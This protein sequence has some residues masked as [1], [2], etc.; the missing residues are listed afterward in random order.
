VHDD[1]AAWFTV[2]LRDLGDEVPAWRGLLAPM[3]SP[4]TASAGVT[5]QFLDHAADYHDRYANVAYFRMVL[6]GAFARLERPPAPRA[7]LDIGSGSGNS[8][9]PLLDRFPDAFVVATD[10]SAPLL[11]ILR[12]H[13]A[14]E[15]RYRGRYALVAVDAVGAP[16][17]R[18]S[19]DLVVGAAILHHVLEPD[20]VIDECR[21][22]L[23]PGGLAV[24]LEP[25]ELGHALLSVVYADIVEE[26]GRRGE[27]GP[28]LAM[29][30]RLLTDYA[31]RRR[32]RDDPRFLEMD[33]KWM[34]TRSFFEAAARRGS[35][36]GCIVHPL[37]DATAPLADQTRVNLKLG[38]GLD[39]DAL[40]AW[41]WARI[42]ACEQSFSP[43]ARH[44]LAFECAVLLRAWPGDAATPH[45][46]SG[47]W[48]DAVA[49]GRGF[50]VTDDGVAAS[51][52]CCHYDAAG[53]PIWAVAG[54]AAW[55]DGVMSAPAAS[56]AFAASSPPATAVAP[57]SLR[58]ESAT[59]ARITWASEDIEV[60]PQHADSPGWRRDA[61]HE[62]GGR[63]VEDRADPAAWLVVEALDGRVFAALL[64]ADGWSV[65]VAAE[66]RLDICA[67]DWLRF[68][69]GQPLGGPY[70]PP[71]EPVVLGEARLLWTESDRLVVQMP[72]GRHVAMRRAR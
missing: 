3:G 65:T 36:T 40:P 35:W 17:T 58:F 43:A 46:R 54:P 63:W 5:S 59:R 9:I 44:E 41:A 72:D 56:S 12:D 1:P 38:S 24:F 22:A 30:R 52:T 33:D 32:R 67:G 14:A 23:R 34:F 27:D 20:R 68:S 69:G 55:R 51:V 42:A 53:A 25:F 21:V 50:F 61:G 57:L 31:A 13:L 70:R 48:F 8:V 60:V 10:I 18:A 15:P 28:G 29:V 2:P 71:R 45:P 19:F 49:P 62:R 26:A 7:I 39:A 47:W 64:T 4:G 37:H 16:L 66:R 6:D 11:A